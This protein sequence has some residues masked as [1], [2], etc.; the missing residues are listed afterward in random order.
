VLAA[1]DRVL[2][3]TQKERVG[4]E[5]EVLIDQ[6]ASSGTPAVGRTASDAPEV[7]LLAYVERCKAQ[8]GERVR[9][10]VEGVDRESNLI[11]GPQARR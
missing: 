1:R 9:V 7:D 10:R 3:A 5:I 8:A 2:A 4:S 6:P 11:C